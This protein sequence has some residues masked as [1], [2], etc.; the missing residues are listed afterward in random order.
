MSENEML[1]KILGYKKDEVHEQSH[2]TRK[3]VIYTTHLELQYYTS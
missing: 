2:T 1:N 3:F